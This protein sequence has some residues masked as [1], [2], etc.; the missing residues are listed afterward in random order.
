MKENQPYYK[1]ILLIA[2][3]TSSFFLPFGLQR[4]FR[5]TFLDV[6]SLNNLELGLCFSVY[7]IVALFSYF[8]GGGLADRFK[9]NVLIASSLIFTA[10]GGFYMATYPSFLGLKT[11]YGYWGFTTI[12]LFWAA[13]IK[14]TRIWG[15]SAKQLRAFAFL[16]G[17]RGLIAALLGSLGVAV[18]GSMLAEGIDTVNADGKRDAFRLVIQIISTIVLIVGILS[19]IFL[20]SQD[21]GDKDI[22]DKMGFAQLSEVLKIPSVWYL[23]VIILCAY[24]AYKVTDIASLYANEV[25]EYDEIQS[26]NLATFLLFLRPVVG[27][28]MGIFASSIKSTKFLILSFILVI[29]GSLLF[30]SGI[31]SPSSNALFLISVIILA[32]GT[33]SV[34]TLY[35][36]VLQEGRI[37][38]YL[39]GTAVGLISFIG[40]TPDIFAG[41][42][43]GVLLDDNPGEYGHQLVFLLLG[44]ISVLG[45][46]AAIGFGRY[47]KSGRTWN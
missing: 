3:G 35:F 22:S 43:M 23:M 26:A 36:A 27:L 13:M 11:L 14:A 24:F 31:N 32:V 1:L 47:V 2:A 16:D 46:I 5:P 9:P 38:L 10:A 17:G 40:Y 12:F 41:P 34:R 45:L 15:G 39:T 8:F 6:F 42:L 7:G 29:G 20:R 44:A 19:L 21:T 4:V 30:A 18:F 28:A 25:M 37:P 33:Y